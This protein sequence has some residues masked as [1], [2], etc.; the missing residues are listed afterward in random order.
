[1]RNMKPYG[2]PPL[3]GAQGV[4]ISISEFQLIKTSN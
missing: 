4:D 3:E 1:M 2:C